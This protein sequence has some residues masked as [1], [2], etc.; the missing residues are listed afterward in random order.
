MTELKI[1]PNKQLENF[2]LTECPVVKVT[3][4]A[5]KSLLETNLPRKEDM[6]MS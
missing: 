6:L 4:E 1:S 5:L 3:V 2:N